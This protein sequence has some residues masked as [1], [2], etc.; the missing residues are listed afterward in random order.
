[1]S[2]TLI[3]EWLAEIHVDLKEQNKLLQNIVD[4]MRVK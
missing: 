1:M 3:A 4:I 2:E